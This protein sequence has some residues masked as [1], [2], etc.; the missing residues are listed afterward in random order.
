MGLIWK[1]LTIKK[2]TLLSL[3]T[4]IIPETGGESFGE[5]KNFSVKVAK[6]ENV[7]FLHLQNVQF[8]HSL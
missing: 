2:H 1:N 3:V 7:L 8:H 5:I 4:K 6:S